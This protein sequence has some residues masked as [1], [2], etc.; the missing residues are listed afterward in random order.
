MRCAQ[1]EWGAGS[2]FYVTVDLSVTRPISA[3]QPEYFV[4]YVL[5]SS[6][7]PFFEGGTFANKALRHLW[8]K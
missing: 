3:A 4:N 1:T 5:H 6:L 7:V 2:S 8:R